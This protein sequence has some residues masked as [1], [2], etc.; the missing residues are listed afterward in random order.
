MDMHEEAQVLLR[1]SKVENCS[2]P[3]N[4]IS[5]ICI[6]EYF[7]QGGMHSELLFLEVNEEYGRNSQA[8]ESN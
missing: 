7:F 1:E 8:L 5:E 3:E 4:D 2:D 6:S